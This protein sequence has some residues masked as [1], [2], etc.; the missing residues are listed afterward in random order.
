MSNNV[1]GSGNILV[2]KINK[3]LVLLKLIFWVEVGE[4]N[5]TNQLNDRC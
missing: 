4:M 1:V 5:K 2:D 3:S